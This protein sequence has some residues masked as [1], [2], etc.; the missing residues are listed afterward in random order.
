MS[1]S[2]PPNKNTPILLAT[3]NPAKQQTLRW[4]LEGL[5]FSP[6]TPRELGL[7]LSP[8]EEG[9][10]HEAIACLKAREWSQAASMLA[11]ASDGGLVIPVLGERWESRF[12][13]RF[14]G[15][16]AD[17]A[18]R[19]R[20]LLELMQ[21]YQ[22]QQRKASWV[23][24][25]AIADRGRALASWDLK[26]STGVIAESPDD[27]PQVPGFWVFSVW[28]FPHL[29]KTYNQLSSQEKEALDDHWTRL[30][31]LVQDFFKSRRTIG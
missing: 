30:R 3:S 1:D 10:T 7:D 14:A 31:Q 24:A 17:D 8:E 22:G 13:H 11:I 9:E 29:G 25:L 4:L 20:R 23:E 16:A 28:R 19:L 2:L 12:T 27:S 26:G 15:P 5:P 21:P 18:E 6:V